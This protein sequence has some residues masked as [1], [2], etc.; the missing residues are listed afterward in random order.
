M[1]ALTLFGRSIRAVSD[2]S[3]E[4]LVQA[5][6]GLVSCLRNDKTKQVA[7]L[8]FVI[9]MVGLRVFA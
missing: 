2:L 1:S 8:F 9:L 6:E 4:L 5:E 7:S 3:R